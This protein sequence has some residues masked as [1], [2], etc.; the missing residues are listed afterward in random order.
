MKDASLAVCVPSQGLTSYQNDLMK[1]AAGRR[2]MSEA[3]RRAALKLL[4]FICSHSQAIALCFSEGAGH[5]LPH[6]EAAF[7]L[8][9]PFS[10]PCQQTGI[11]T[12][13]LFPLVTALTLPETLL[14]ILSVFLAKYNE[15]HSY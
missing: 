5:K 10:A 14:R 7:G 3:S 12:A 8:K 4:D 2:E 15:N 13:L 1:G 6:D 9:L 11:T